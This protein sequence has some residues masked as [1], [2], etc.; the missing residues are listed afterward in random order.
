MIPTT[1][2]EC[3]RAFLFSNFT[4]LGFPELAPNMTLEHFYQEAKTLDREWKLRIRSAATASKARQLG[5]GCPI[6]TYWER[7]KLDVMRK[8]LERKFR[9]EPW[10]TKLATFEGELVEWNDWHDTFWGKCICPTHGGRGLNVLGQMLTQIRGNIR[11][12]REPNDYQRG[13]A[14][15]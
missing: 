15:S 11:D 4:V 14:G 12:G 13:A 7:L 8:L 6:Q 1:R 3:R 2:E 5:N 9:R 10:R